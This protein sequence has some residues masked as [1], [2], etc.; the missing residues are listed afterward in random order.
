MPRTP[1]KPAAAPLLGGWMP[2]EWWGK[3]PPK[4]FHTKIFHTENRHMP[5]AIRNRRLQQLARLIK[6]RH[7][8][9]VETT[10]IKQELVDNLRQGRMIV[11]D[12]GYI[13][14]AEKIEMIGSWA[15]S[16]PVIEDDDE[17]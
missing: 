9:D 14:W 17:E 13:G 4:I 16:L 8:Y 5:A 12:D 10:K 3:H 15:Y 6:A 7:D 2:A 11:R 1:K